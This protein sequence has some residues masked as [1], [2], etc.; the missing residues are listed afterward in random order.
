M[1]LYDLYERLTPEER[2]KA[3][4]SAGARKDLADWDRL[5]DT[6]PT[7]QISS[8]EP[9]YFA[10]IQKLWLLSLLHNS[11]RRLLALEA[12]FAMSMLAVLDEDAA[13]AKSDEQSTHDSLMQTAALCFARVRAMD[14]A[15][16][17]FVSSIG[18]QP[19]EA[20][21]VCGMSEELEGT[22]LEILGDATS[23]Y[24][25]EQVAERER[26][27]RDD[28]RSTLAHFWQRGIEEQWGKLERG[29]A[30]NKG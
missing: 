7:R 22:L 14:A 16:D 29:Y 9:S 23:S 20:R 2:F 1:K 13:E 27:Q 8:Q 25:D 28:W 30:K 15:F 5:N 19:A 12:T 10:R 6:S 11:Q 26:E 18:L 17:E 24:A 21:S 3:A 4:V